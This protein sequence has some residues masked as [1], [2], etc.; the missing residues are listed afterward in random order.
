MLVLIISYPV[1]SIIRLRIFGNTLPV[2]DAIINYAVLEIPLHSSTWNWRL[3]DFFYTSITI[4]RLFK[5][6]SVQMH[7]E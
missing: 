4:S 6:S 7:S 1:L 5:S 3:G 2:S